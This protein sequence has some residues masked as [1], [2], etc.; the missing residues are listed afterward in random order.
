[1]AATEPT[2][3]PA[4]YLEVADLEEVSFKELTHRRVWLLDA[5]GSVPPDTDHPGIR[6][7]ALAL[8]AVLTELHNRARRYAATRDHT[9]WCLCG[10]H[11]VGL[12]AF[13]VHFDQYPPEA[14]EGAHI[15]VTEDY[16]AEQAANA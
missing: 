10:F 7:A 14:P 4:G 13:E 3:A 2:T 11:S 5:I 8:V 6:A 15:E 16:A 12:A 1:M 9:Y